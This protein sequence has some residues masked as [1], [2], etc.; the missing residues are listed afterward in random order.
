MTTPE[1]PE[2]EPETPEA[3]APP[4]VLAV[5][6][7]RNPGPWLEEALASLSDQ[8]YPRLTTLVVDVAST[9]DPSARVEQALPGALVRR[10]AEGTGFATAANNALAALE[11]VPFLLVC[12][13]DV[14]LEPAALRL[15]I[16]EAYRSNAG[17]VGPK[18]VEADNPE[19]LLEVGRS[20][21]RYGAPHTG[22]EPGELDQEQHDGVRDVFYVSSAAML[23]RSDLFRELGGFDPATFPGAEDLDLCW[24]ARLAGARV[25]VAPDARVRHREAA[26]Q[27]GKVDRRDARAIARSRVRALLTSYSFWSLLWVVPVGLVLAFGEAIVSILTRRRGRAR[28]ALGGWW[29]NLRHLGEVRRSRRRA[30]KLRRIHDGE[31]RELQVRGSAQVRD[32]LSQHLHTEERLLSLTEAGRS[33]AAAA[34]TGARQPVALAGLVVL[35]L[36][37][38]GSRDLVFGRVPAVGTL[39][40]WPGVF[41]LLEAYSSGWRF[42]GL[43]SPAAAPP[44]F[45]FMAALG[46]PLL[47]A[48]GLARTLVVVGALPLGAIGAY[49]LARP[50]VGSAG[51]AGVAAL[52]YA[53]NPVPRNAIAAG[54]L[55]PLVLYAL[56]PFLVATVVRGASGGAR[57][58]GSGRVRRY[59]GLAVGTAIATAFFPPA[60]LWMLAAGVAV[61]VASPAV[62][63]VGLGLRM[64]GITLVGIGGALVLLVPWPLDFPGADG[65]ALG[66]AFRPALSLAE[67]LR[68]ESGPSGAGW[69]G[70][71]LLIAAALSLAIATGP[72]LAWAARA[73]ALALLGFAAVW[74]PSRFGPDVSVPAPEAALSLAALGL[75]LAI[76]L[77]VAALVEGE[78][79]RYRFGWRQP[80]VAL[81]GVGIVLSVVG[82]AADAADG[83]WHAPARDWHQVLG[84]LRAERADG[85][86]RVLWVGDPAVLPFDPAVAGGGVGYVLTRDGPGNGRELFRAPERRADRLVGDAIDLVADDRTNR[87]GHLLAPMAVRYIAVPARAGPRAEVVGGASFSTVADALD[88][89]TDLIRLGTQPDVVLYENA[90][91]AATR[92]T[93]D[94]DAAEDLPL[95]S[96]AP[97]RAALRTELDVAEPVKGPVGD[98]APTGPGTVL[99]S[100]A[101]DADWEAR[102]GGNGLDHVEPFGFANGY[103][104]P[105]RGSVSITYEGQL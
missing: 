21:D 3:G 84:F 17:I 47:G 89:Q 65:A 29:W 79:Q 34:S 75:A 30:Q 103:V 57:A 1:A 12:H 96:R 95:D 26:K 7:T 9:E 105:D 73:W 59:L 37:L 45:A 94:E 92:A 78:L 90:A 48:T 2:A 35:V 4:A 67:V 6:V 88:A 24:R 69:A 36:F 28:A 31:L 39:A 33:A 98:S 16:E 66:F 97:L 101:F 8:D 99:W 18:L 15:L 81:A 43:G 32:Y 86:F 76:A 5:L 62:G 11:D 104:L 83:R 10:V 82:F 63:G 60:P 38:V 80:V 74:L 25:L 91:W 87:L 14:V 70:F 71:G 51:P 20:I 56:G 52:A 22:I 64:L 46:A 85:G 54:R 53:I 27:R 55:G 100:E 23:V 41:D 42:T 61:L 93:L 13:D 19:V 49:R 68:F 58:I 77:G 50:L 72:R 40:P 44:A 102:A